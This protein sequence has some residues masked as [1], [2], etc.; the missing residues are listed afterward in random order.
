MKWQRSPLTKKIL[1]IIRKYAD[2]T[3]SRYDAPYGD[4]AREDDEYDPEQGRPI[5][6][7]ITH[8]NREILVFPHEFDSYSLILK[9]ELPPGTLG[10]FVDK[11]SIGILDQKEIYF[12]ARNITDSN[13]P[14]NNQNDTFYFEYNKVISYIG[15]PTKEYEFVGR[16]EVKITELPGFTNGIPTNKESVTNLSLKQYYD[17]FKQLRPDLADSLEACFND[18][19]TE[20]SNQ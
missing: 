18:L 3:I 14:E 15:R 20:T 17:T 13:E 4:Y 6:I 7:D 10:M 9:Q 5:E 19:R 11:L 1:R 16:R 2:G 12:I 8:K